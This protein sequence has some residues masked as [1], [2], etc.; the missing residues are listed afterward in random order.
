[1]AAQVNTYIDLGFF[2]RHVVLEFLLCF[3]VT[4]SYYFIHY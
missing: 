1:M 4:S 3:S 2:E